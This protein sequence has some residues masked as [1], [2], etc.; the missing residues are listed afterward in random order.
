M[1]TESIFI[2]ENGKEYQILIG[3][4][5]YEN[6]QIIKSS[7]SNDIWFHLNDYSSCHIILQSGDDNIPKKYLTDIAK[8]FSLYKK[9]LPKK[10]KVIYTNIKNIKLTDEI[11]TVIPQNSKIIKI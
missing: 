8:M 3:R 9:G 4:N 1:K 5:K 11:G 2:T 7:Y 10:Y 6:E